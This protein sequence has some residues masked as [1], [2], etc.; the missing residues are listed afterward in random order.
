MVLV[1]RI[2]HPARAEVGREDRVELVHRVRPHVGVRHKAFSPASLPAHDDVQ[3]ETGPAFRHPTQ[4]LDA[5]LSVPQVRL[6]SVPLHAATVHL[7]TA[8]GV[9]GAA[10]LDFAAGCVVQRAHASDLAAVRRSILQPLRGLLHGCARTL[11]HIQAQ[12]FM[13]YFKKRATHLLCDDQRRTLLTAVPPFIFSS[14]R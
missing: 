6:S 9:R 3:A 1:H 5:L 10:T 2:F 4:G 14:Y 8:L 11:L 7:K 13:L 12:L